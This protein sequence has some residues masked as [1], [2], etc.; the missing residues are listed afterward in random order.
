MKS[1][2]SHEK[3]ETKDLRPLVFS[4]LSIDLAFWCFL[5]W[6]FMWFARFQILISEPQSTWRKLLV[7]SWLYVKSLFAPWCF[8]LLLII[9]MQT[10]LSEYFVYFLKNSPSFTNLNSWK[11]SSSWN[12][13]KSKLEVFVRLDVL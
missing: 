5:F 2:K 8:W 12:S 3:N 6:F 10:E 7:L 9:E 1:C 4:F 13:W 11:F